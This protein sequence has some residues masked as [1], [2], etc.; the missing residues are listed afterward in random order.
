MHPSSG[1][2]HENILYNFST[3]LKAPLYIIGTILLTRLQTLFRGLH[4]LF[5][6]FIAYKGLVCVCV[7]YLFNVHIS[8]SLF[9][10]VC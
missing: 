3:S 1:F 6:V 9:N 4:Q 8:L 2:P 10:L 7:C 5:Y